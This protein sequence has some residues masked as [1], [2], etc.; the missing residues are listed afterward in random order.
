MDCVG[1][2]NTDNWT[3]N[4]KHVNVRGQPSEENNVSYIVGN[5]AHIYSMKS[6][7]DLINVRSPPKG[8]S[9]CTIFLNDT[10]IT[11]TE[12]TS[13]IF[14][15]IERFCLFLHKSCLSNFVTLGG[16]LLILWQVNFTSTKFRLLNQSVNTRVS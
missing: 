4:A 14:N 7:K 5:N 13:Q 3:N 10:L 11:T 1:I 12:V 15:C 8:P 9:L 2:A 16:K 6:S